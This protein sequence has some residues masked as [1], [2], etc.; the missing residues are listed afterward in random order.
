MKIEGLNKYSIILLELISARN[1]SDKTKF[2]A[3]MY[4][5][6]TDVYK[7]DFIK[8][9]PIE[10]YPVLQELIQFYKKREE[11][12]KCHILNQVGIEIYNTISD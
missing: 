8:S 2:Y 7:K 12:E 6:I 1:S 9:K 11:F 5:A 3:K 10:L 4:E